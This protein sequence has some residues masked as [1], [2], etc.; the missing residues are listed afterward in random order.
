M[1]LCLGVDYIDFISIL[2]L[3]NQKQE[4]RITKL[5][6]V[7]NLIA[8]YIKDKIEVSEKLNEIKKNRT[9]RTPRRSNE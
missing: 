8:P 2:I 5:E 9:P 1:P 6:G 7:L 4:E 3:W